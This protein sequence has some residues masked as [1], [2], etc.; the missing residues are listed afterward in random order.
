[1]RVGQSSSR[2]QHREVPSCGK[3]QV[4]SSPSIKC[5]T[6][7]RAGTGVGE[8]VHTMRESMP[9]HTSCE[10]SERVVSPAPHR[11]VVEQRTRV[12]YAQ[13]EEHHLRKAELPLVVG[14]PAPDGTIVENRARVSGPPDDR[15]HTPVRSTHFVDLENTHRCPGLH[16]RGRT[17]GAARRRDGE[18]SGPAG[19]ARA[20]AARRA[21]D[22][23]RAR[24]R[25][26]T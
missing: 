1:M 16:E 20:R 10:L 11:L 17:P 7:G 8:R 19:G 18:E 13:R 15:S 23:G 24:R 21:I 26:R 6:P 3:T 5:P 9:K 14:S 12:R 22:R 2:F 25:C 4:T